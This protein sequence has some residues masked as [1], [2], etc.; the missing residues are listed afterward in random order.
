[1]TLRHIQ[2][3]LRQLAALAGLRDAD[4]PT[5]G[6]SADGGRPHIE[7]IDGLYYYVVCERGTELERSLFVDEHELCYLALRD[8]TAQAAGN[9]ELATRG[10]E[11]HDSRRERFRIQEDLLRRI[12][13]EWA[14][15]ITQEHALVLRKH[16]FD[17][18][19][20]VRLRRFK[21]MSASGVA[22]EEAWQ[23]ACVEYPRPIPT[24]K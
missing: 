2:E 18:A 9:R 23:R 11:L 14:A 21:E 8:A 6:S 17:D 13:P 16:P 10:D 3:H 19:A 5:F 4:L 24:E 7:T 20:V 1:M 12:E 22:E 15:R